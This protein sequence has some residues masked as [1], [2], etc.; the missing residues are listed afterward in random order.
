MKKGGEK[1]S[2]G[3]VRSVGSAPPPRLPLLRPRCER[4]RRSH[5]R[6]PLK[7]AAVKLTTFQPLRRHAAQEA[8]HYPPVDSFAFVV[9]FS[10]RGFVRLLSFVFVYM[11]TYSRIVTV[12]VVTL[13]LCLLKS[14]IE[15]MGRTLIFFFNGSSSSLL[16]PNTWQ[17]RKAHHFPLSK[18]V[19]MCAHCDIT[20]G[21]ATSPWLVTAP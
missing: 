3:H 11:H 10:P 1:Q 18:L 16:S 15:R 13:V 19:R 7:Y 2:A 12:C 6:P 20:K 5:A 4:R 17:I 14:A 8:G 21:T 9:F